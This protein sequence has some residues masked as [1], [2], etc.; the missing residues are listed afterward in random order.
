MLPNQPLY[1]LPWLRLLLAIS[2]LIFVGFSN[3]SASSIRLQSESAEDEPSDL[4]PVSNSI[5]GSQGAFEPNERSGSSFA[6]STSTSSD[7]RLSGFQTQTLSCPPGETVTFNLQNFVLTGHSTLTLSGDATGT[8]IFNVTKQFSLTHS[9]RIVLSGGIQW[10]QVFFNVLGTGP[11]VTLSGESHLI[12]TL[13]ANQRV[14]RMN[15]HAIAY[16]KVFAKRIIIRQAAQII[17]GS[18]VSH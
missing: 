17:P 18:I 1:R 6:F 13:T 10:N 9:A 4:L 15:D 7:I 16:G 3:A 12:G 14:V 5:L 8:F 11:R 2:I